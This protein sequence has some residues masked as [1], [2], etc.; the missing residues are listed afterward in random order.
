MVRPSGA[1]SVASS[2]VGAESVTRPGP[3]SVTVYDG[4]AAA[5]SAEPAQQESIRAAPDRKSLRAVGRIIFILEGRGIGILPPRG[6]A[7]ARPGR[8]RP[9]FARSMGGPRRPGT[10]PREG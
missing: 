8:G 3:R 2:P 4:S 10:T 9:S 7:F 6:D 5:P 1:V